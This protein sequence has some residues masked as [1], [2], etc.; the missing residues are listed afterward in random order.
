MTEDVF[1]NSCQTCLIDYIRGKKIKEIIFE[2]DYSVKDENL[3]TRINFDQEE[4]FNHFYC[5]Y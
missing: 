5:R 2:Q 3:G 4:Q 1:F